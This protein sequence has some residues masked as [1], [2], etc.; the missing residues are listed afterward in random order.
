MSRTNS[1]ILVFLLF[2][3][4]LF[5]DSCDFR[6][7]FSNDTFY[8]INTNVSITIVKTQG[9]K[10]YPEP[11]FTFTI[12]NN[13]K[14][15]TILFPFSGATF[16]DKNKYCVDYEFKTANIHQEYLKYVVIP[17]N[18]NWTDSIFIEGVHT[19]F[20]FDFQYVPDYMDEA[21]HSNGAY[22]M[23]YSRDYP[24]KGTIYS[25]TFETSLFSESSKNPFFQFASKRLISK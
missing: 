2:S 6:V 18:T 4:I 17:P 12:T 10:Q 24:I 1:I 7:R 13:L 21:P 22:M 3:N 25:C 5:A 14:S 9:I 20:E 23:R 16:H 19:N 15:N 8:L 11:Q